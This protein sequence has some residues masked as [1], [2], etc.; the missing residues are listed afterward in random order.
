MGPKLDGSRRYQTIKPAVTATSGDGH[1]AGFLGGRGVM[2]CQ[3]DL[4]PA[5]MVARS[6]FKQEVMVVVNKASQAVEVTMASICLVIRHFSPHCSWS[7]RISERRSCSQS[8]QSLNLAQP[9]VASARQ[10]PQN[11]AAS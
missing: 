2:R 11:I 4:Q 7:N 6:I 1:T 3:P 9:D 8:H 10:S 5:N